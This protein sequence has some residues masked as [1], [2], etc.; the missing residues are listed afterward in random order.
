MPLANHLLA[1]NPAGIWT[2]ES[3]NDCF[4]RWK[5]LWKM[6]APQQ[7][8]PRSM[9]GC[10]HL[11]IDLVVRAVRTKPVLLPPLPAYERI[12]IKCVTTTEQ[13][14]LKQQHCCLPS[15]APLER[16]LELVL[17]RFQI[18][19]SVFIL[20]HTAGTIQIPEALLP[21]KWKITS[22]SAYRSV[23]RCIQRQT[24][25]CLGIMLIQWHFNGAVER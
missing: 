3:R 7:Y 25:P 20:A 13:V 5:S 18:S 24:G 6:I 15:E 22:R 19:H 8:T 2:Q 11:M 1:V 14:L 17:P 16:Y 10:C 12:S 21:R 4:F 23:I 9:A